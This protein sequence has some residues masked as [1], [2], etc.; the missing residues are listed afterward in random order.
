MNSVSILYLV[1]G[2]AS[3]AALRCWECNNVGSNEECI[4]QG[5]L[6][7]CGTNQDACQIELRHGGWG[8][9]V[10]I[11]KRCKQSQ[12]CENNFNQNPQ[13]AW[14]FTQCNLRVPSSVCRCCCKGN[15]CN[16]GSLTCWTDNAT[17]VPSHTNPR[18]GRVSCTN[19]NEVGSS[20]SFDCNTG[21]RLIG[22]PT[23]VCQDDQTW[24]RSAPECRPLVCRPRLMA[25]SNGFMT[26]DKGNY[27]ESE[28][29]FR[30]NVGYRLEGSE[31][32]VCQN[33]ETWS[34][35]APECQP[36]LCPPPHVAPPNGNVKCTNNNLLGSRCR[37]KC[38]K[39]YALVGDRLST[40]VESN[41]RPYDSDG[42][43][44]TP[45]PK[46]QRITCIP[47]MKSPLHGSMECTDGSNAG[48]RCTFH[49]EDGYSMIG[50][51]YTACV[52][53]IGTLRGVWQNPAPVCRPIQCT[54]SQEDPD[55]GRVFCSNG[56]QLGSVCRFMC[57]H[58]YAMLGTGMTTCL[59]DGNGDTIGTWSAPPSRCK[60]I[61]CLPLHEAPTNGFVSC[62]NDAYLGSVC[63]FT[64]ADDYKL[65]GNPTCTCNEGRDGGVVGRWSDF[66]PVCRRKTCP[67]G[68]MDPLNGGTVCSDGIFLGSQCEFVC[69]EYHMRVG[70]LYSTCVELDDGSVEW[71][72]PTPRCRPITCPD[73][74][75]LPHGE[76]SC[77]KSNFATSRCNFKCTAEKYQLY[78]PGVTENHCMNNSRWNI[79]KPCCARSCPPFAVMDFVV[80]LDSSSSVG[81]ENWMKIKTFTH[82]FLSTF[83]LSPEGSQYS[84]FRYNR[85][86][87]INSQI[88][89]KDHPT[90]IEDFIY[91]F[92]QIP[93][94]GSGTHTGKAINH[95]VDI[96]LAPGNGNRVNA[97]DI[98]LVITDG[99]SQDDVGGPALRLR[100]TGATVFVLPIMPPKGRLD[101]RQ[102][103]QIAGSEDNIIK[104]AIEGGFEALTE[105]FSKKVSNIICGNPCKHVLHDHLAL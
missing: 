104:D 87:D 54:P 16:K 26:C 41:N 100:Q 28:C 71:D 94:D 105:H 72:Q 31:T 90:N 2:L 84:V 67:G 68:L 51:M 85:N 20:C 62:T 36:I 8:Y 4:Q 14:E 39:D 44:N 83:I 77:T 65:M 25:P 23:S 50:S 98:V 48:S 86:V 43:W 35:A 37:F 10:M 69:D 89:L 103:R 1:A 80:I 21:Y 58:G 32:S 17:C 3:V 57:S 22:S 11:S 46:C 45:A 88:L 73:Q 13:S 29:S 38:N 64:C 60:P 95:A 82:Q 15:E 74:F 97:R 27:I 101:M 99:K 76:M 63:H 79:E 34:N 78:P 52:D 12:A 91:A 24:D 47:D 7:Q 56:I 55:N 75:P 93:Y 5:K 53:E 19:T 6:V 9:K 49:C 42:V 30:C 66:A 70:A 40:C 92:E 102:V 61:V 59:N 33:D 81:S 96:V 18:N